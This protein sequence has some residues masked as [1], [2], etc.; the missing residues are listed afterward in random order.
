ME[1]GRFELSIEVTDK[2]LDDLNHVNNVVY[3]QWVQDAAAAHWNSL[4]TPFIQQTYFWVV[5]RHEINYRWPA[6]SGDSLVAITW[7]ETLEGVRSDRVVEL[8][9]KSDG[10]LLADARTTWCLMSRITNKPTRIGEDIRQIFQ[11][12][13]G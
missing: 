2:D 1:S 8:R 4:A 13:G 7:V 5:I 10:R 3:L 12:T 9:R 11:P 6:L